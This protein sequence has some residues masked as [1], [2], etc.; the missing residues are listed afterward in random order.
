MKQ[1]GLTNQVDQ[2]LRES[3]SKTSATLRPNPSHDNVLNSNSNISPNSTTLRNNP[4]YQH[5][6]QRHVA[7]YPSHSNPNDFISAGNLE[8]SMDSDENV[9]SYLTS[10]RV[11]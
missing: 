6:H 3:N 8:H 7:N 1:L 5:H 10:S 9:S 2:V 11:D 4:T